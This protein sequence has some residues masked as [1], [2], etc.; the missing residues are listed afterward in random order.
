MVVETIYEGWF[1]IFNETVVP[2]LI[3]QPKWFKV[4]R[5]LKVKDLV[6]F[7]KK[8][9]PIGSPWKI[10][11]VDQVIASRDGLIRRVIIKYFNKMNEDPELTDRSV[12]NIVKL[13]SIDEACLM[14]DLGELQR[15]YDNRGVSG[16]KVANEEV[17]NDDSED[18]HDE[19]ETVTGMAQYQQTS[20]AG[21]KVDDSHGPAT[22][23]VHGHYCGSQMTSQRLSCTTQDGYQFDLAAMGVSCELTALLVHPVAVDADVQE[24]H[25]HGEDDEQAIGLDS[26]H[27]V[28]MSTGFYL[29]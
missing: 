26:L 16:G 25:L 17:G 9:S 2:K 27:G 21:L 12:R 6:Y 14:D 1:K 28:M 23:S 15:R 29:D 24:E 18:E 22:F 11:Q 7:R 20:W 19:A 5:D 4:D 8:D 10:G 13:W 3:M